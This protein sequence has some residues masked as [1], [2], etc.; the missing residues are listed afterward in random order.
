[1]RVV[2]LLARYAAGGTNARG[3]RGSGPPAPSPERR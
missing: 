1:M 3:T 2:L